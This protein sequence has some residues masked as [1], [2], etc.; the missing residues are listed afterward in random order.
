M[1]AEGIST[2][3]L[4]SLDSD[5]II[6]PDVDYNCGELKMLSEAFDIL[7]DLTDGSTS[8]ES[9]ISSTKGEG[10]KA[11]YG[12]SL[13]DDQAATA[14]P[15]GEDG[16]IY[17]SLLIPDDFI[18]N[19]TLMNGL[20][21]RDYDFNT[22]EIKDRRASLPVTQTQLFSSLTKVEGSEGPR[23]IFNGVLNGWPGLKNFE[24]LELEKKRAIGRLSAPDYFSNASWAY[25]WSSNKEGRDGISPA[26]TDKHK[27]YR[28]TL[29][30]APSARKGWS[31]ESPGF[32]FWFEAQKP[33]PK[34]SYGTNLLKEVGKSH[35]YDSLL[36]NFKPLQLPNYEYEYEYSLCLSPPTNE[37]RKCHV[38][39]SA[40][41]QSS[42]FC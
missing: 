29:R 12:V 38:Q 30:T 25:Y 18:S 19:G 15:E 11:V 8:E 5:S 13:D 20:N 17:H 32:V 23:Y 3:S 6:E 7:A 24:L 35:A 37:C 1:E 34:L 10:S 2:E 39:N 14:V 16:L 42:I 27:V 33:V 21:K 22:N 4:T 31:A 9:K 28:A 40:Y 36:L 41:D 26:I